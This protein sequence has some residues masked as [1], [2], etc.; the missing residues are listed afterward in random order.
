MQNPERDTVKDVRLCSFSV[1][2]PGIHT[3]AARLGGC[4][5]AAPAA[6]VLPLCLRTTFF[7][8]LRAHY[9]RQIQKSLSHADTSLPES[10][11]CRHSTQ[12]AKDTRHC[13]SAQRHVLQELLG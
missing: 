5:H 2:R 4:A 8:C 13:H 3:V 11:W 9:G 7:F 10:E 6:P 1:N 12:Y